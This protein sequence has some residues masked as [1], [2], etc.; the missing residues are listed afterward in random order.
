MVLFA[1]LCTSNAYNPLELVSQIQTTRMH[2]SGISKY[3]KIIKNM[4]K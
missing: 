1:Q 4:V 3:V 2:R